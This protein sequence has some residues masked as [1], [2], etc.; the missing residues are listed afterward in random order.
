MTSK[1]EPIIVV[2][3]DPIWAEEFRSIGARMRNVLG[4]MAERIDHIGST[5]IPDLAAKPVIDIQISVKSLEP[6]V[7]QQPLESLGYVLKPDNSQRTK[8]YFRESPGERRTHIHVRKTGSWHQQF[9]LLFRDYLRINAED[10]DLYEATKRSLA[11]KYRN[12]RTAYVD[13]KDPVIWE[14]MQRA[15]TWA[16]EGEWESGKSDA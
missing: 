3:Y 6:M 16:A 7:Y 13:A 8:R 5:S 1:P 15:D 9:P 14:I 4:D 2:E 12:D 11:E 10:R